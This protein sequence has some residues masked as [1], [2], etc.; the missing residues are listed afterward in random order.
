[1]MCYSFLIGIF[2]SIWKFNY[3]ANWATIWVVRMDDM[4]CILPSSTGAFSCCAFKLYCF[5]PICFIYDMLLSSR[6]IQGLWLATSEVGISPQKIQC[7]LLNTAR[8]KLGRCWYLLSIFLSKQ[9]L[10]APIEKMQYKT[11]PYS[12]SLQFKKDLSKAFSHVIFPCNFTKARKPYIS[13]E[14][15]V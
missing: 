12:L 6:P 14:F 1:M 10:V 3:T 5:P 4:T 8:S 11:Y 7:F 15:T 2:S 13:S 9:F